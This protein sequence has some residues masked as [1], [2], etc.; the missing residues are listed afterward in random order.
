MP[1]A[2]V[3]VALERPTVEPE[4]GL[5]RSTLSFQSWLAEV[6]LSKPGLP[7]GVK[8]QV[9]ILVVRELASGWSGFQVATQPTRISLGTPVRVDV[10][11]IGCPSGQCTMPSLQRAS[12]RLMALSRSAP[13]KRRIPA[14]ISAP[15][16]CH[17]SHLA[18]FTWWTPMLN[19]KESKG[20]RMQAFER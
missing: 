9:S 3:V 8:A 17:S 16:A 11:R 6:G 5:R 15:A 2:F 7:V 1:V 20:V 10:T 13:V 4:C 14:A 19:A 18:P 12:S